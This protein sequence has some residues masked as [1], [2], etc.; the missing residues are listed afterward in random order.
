MADFRTVEKILELELALYRI[1][2]TLESLLQKDSQIMATLADL[3]KKVDGLINLVATA[4][5][6]QQTSLADLKAEVIA[7]QNKGT[8]PAAIDALIA[9]ID[10]IST[11]VSALD[12]AAKG[13][14]PGPQVEPTPIPAPA[15]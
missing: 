8:D 14:D 13:A 6:D 3:S 1:E 2:K 15:P 7:L 5:T 12:A 10:G 9:K 4:T 11:S